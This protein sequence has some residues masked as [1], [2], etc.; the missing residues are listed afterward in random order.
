MGDDD[1]DPRIGQLY[2]F[3]VENTTDDG[4]FAV[5]PTKFAELLDSLGATNAL[6]FGGSVRHRPPGWHAHTTPLVAEC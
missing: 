2:E 3:V 4:S 5:E 1:E 6:V